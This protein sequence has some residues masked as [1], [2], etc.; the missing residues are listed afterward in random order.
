MA[1]IT[2]APP[3]WLGVCALLALC[4]FERLCRYW[5]TP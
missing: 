4:E 1:R 2:F 5:V 3:D